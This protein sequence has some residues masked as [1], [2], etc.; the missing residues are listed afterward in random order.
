MASK[1][2][3]YRKPDDTILFAVYYADGRAAYFT[4]A[5]VL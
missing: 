5:S 4:T 3:P 1:P 2:P